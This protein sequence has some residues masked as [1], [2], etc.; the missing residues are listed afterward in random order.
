MSFHHCAL[1]QH[2]NNVNVAP[3]HVIITQKFIWGAVHGEN[4]IVHNIAAIQMPM[5]GF[6]IGIF[7]QFM[8][9]DEFSYNK[10]NRKKRR[11]QELEICCPDVKISNH[12]D[13]SF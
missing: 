3:E 7:L 13:T 12:L 4:I 5:T 2:V 11:E 6:R 1:A 8:Y 10:G 9:L